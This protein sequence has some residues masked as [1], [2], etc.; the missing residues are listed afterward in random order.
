MRVLGAGGMIEY[1]GASA[2]RNVGANPGTL[3][4]VGW[5]GDF[6]RGMTES[7]IST[8]NTES[9][10]HPQPSSLIHA[11]TVQNLTTLHPR[12]FDH[13]ARHV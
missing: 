4:G 7:Y 6:D 11:H 12:M 5:K 10:S 2:M 9:Q 1:K 3:R 13:A 8:A